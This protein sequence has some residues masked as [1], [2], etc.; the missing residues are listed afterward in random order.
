MSKIAVVTDSTCCIPEEM[1]KEN[2]IYV[3][4]LNIIWDKVQYRDGVDLKPLEFYKRLRT[5]TDSLPTTSS[6][7]QGAF[8]ELFE[9]LNGKVDAV[10]AILIGTRIPTAAVRSALA[11]AEMVP[12]L[13]VE[14]V[15]ADITGIGQGFAVLAAAKVANAGGSLEDIVEAGRSTAA[16]THTWWLQESLD[17]IRKGGRVQIP[18]LNDDEWRDVKPLMTFIDGKIVPFDK[19]PT[20]ETA[21]KYI[22]QLMAENIKAGSPPHVGVMHADDAEGARELKNMVAQQ[23]DCSELFIT[24]FT[25]IMGA[26]FGPGS[27]GLSF[28]ND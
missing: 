21:L 4:P 6:G 28:Y 1:V 27:L 2:G 25:P 3:V 8:L 22:L 16:K 18:Q 10:A 24:D 5:A 12:E 17:Y 26:H 7:V 13:T 11:A 19:R 20:K 9:E 15:D 14:V 23:F